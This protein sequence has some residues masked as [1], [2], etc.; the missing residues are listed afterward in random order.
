M[1]RTTMNTERAHVQVVPA[2]PGWDVVELV[3]HPH[4]DNPEYSPRFS[5]EP[6]IAWR[7]ETRW[8]EHIEEYVSAAYPVCVQTAGDG[9]ILRRPDGYIV[10]VEDREFHGEHVADA[11]TYAIEK[12]GKQR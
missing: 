6:V 11:R 1:P 12:H 5:Y 10:F 8:V 3:P 2:A 7:I 9:D 4:T